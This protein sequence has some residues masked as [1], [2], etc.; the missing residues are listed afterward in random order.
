MA[1]EIAGLPESAEVD[2]DF[3]YFIIENHKVVNKSG[4]FRNIAGMFRDDDF[5]E[6]V[7]KLKRQ[8][9]GIEAVIECFVT[10]LE[11][12]GQSPL[13]WIMFDA[14]SAKYKIKA[15]N[16]FL[17]TER[18]VKFVEEFV[19]KIRDCENWY[20]LFIIMRKNGPLYMQLDKLISEEKRQSEMNKGIC[21]A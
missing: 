9:I 1:Q 4:M 16:V 8:S 11:R 19:K 7:S 15:V 21:R 20:K 17:S 13:S 18:G 5:T 6:I 14:M 3:W 10:E 2:F 12:E